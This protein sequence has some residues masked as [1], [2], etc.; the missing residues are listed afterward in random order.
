MKLPV[1]LGLG[2]LKPMTKEQAIRYGKRNMPKDLKKAGFKVS[3]FTS[4]PK[5]H[6]SLYYRINYG[7]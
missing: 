2:E 4:D 3:V 5:I 7:K 6:G 1:K